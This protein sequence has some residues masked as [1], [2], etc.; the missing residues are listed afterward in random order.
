L[1][2]NKLTEGNMPSFFARGALAFAASIYSV[3]AATAQTAGNQA[4][5]V[6]SGQTATLDCFGGK[7]EIMGSSNK[8]T[9]TGRC[10]ALELAGS[11]NTITIEFAAGATVSFVGS[12]N[13]ITWTSADGKAP[14]VTYIGSNNTMKPPP[15]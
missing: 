15:T 8:L 4:G 1:V 2:V 12:S 10:S 7:A 9:I 6:N 14:K 13:A 3:G 5:F 11:G